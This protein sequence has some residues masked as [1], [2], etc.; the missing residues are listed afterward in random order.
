MNTYKLVTYYKR[1]EREFP[2]ELA[3]REAMEA[4][5]LIAKAPHYT[6]L[7]KMTSKEDGEQLGV[8]ESSKLGLK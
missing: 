2:T 5:S 1:Y 7:W 8:Y 3:A 4:H 6:E